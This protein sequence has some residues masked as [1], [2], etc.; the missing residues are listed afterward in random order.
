MKLIQEVHDQS[1][2]DHLE[3]LRTMKAIRK[4]YY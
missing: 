3:I 4:Y 2:I 1:F